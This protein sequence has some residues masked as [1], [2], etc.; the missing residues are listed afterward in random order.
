MSVQSFMAIYQIVVEISSIAIPKNVS[1]VQ[2]ILLS[3]LIHLG[4]YMGADLWLLLCA[5][6]GRSVTCC[7][8]SMLFLLFEAREHCS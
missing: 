5:L 6:K 8:F 2:N 7:H 1:V 3:V 4:G